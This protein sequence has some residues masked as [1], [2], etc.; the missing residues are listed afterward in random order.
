MKNIWIGQSPC[1][2]FNVN[3]DKN[4]CHKIV[5]HFIYNILV[6]RNQ[7]CLTRL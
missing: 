6:A 7:T 2:T 4:K 1:K 5:D 3:Y